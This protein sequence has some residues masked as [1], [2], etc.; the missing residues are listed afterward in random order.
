MCP[1]PASMSARKQRIAQHFAHATSYEQHAHIQQHVCQRL[2][3]QIQSRTPARLLE[4]GAGSGQLTRLLAAHLT[5]TAWHINE[6][7]DASRPSLQAL[8]P[9]AVLHIGDA[10][11]IDLGTAYD[12]IISANAI[13]WFDQ[14][15][16]FV[17]QSA[18]RLNIGGQLLFSTFT[19]NNFMQ[20]KTLLNQGLHYPSLLEWESVLRSAGLTDIKIQ[21]ERFEVPFASPYAVLKH[22]KLTGVSTNTLDTPFVWNKARLATFTQDYWATFGQVGADNAPYVPLTYEILT[23]SANKA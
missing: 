20:I 5:A 16:S 12:L 3:A 17:T 9:H 22:M 2:L 15:L 13:Q 1:A 18:A 8:L 19:P 6:L 11:T 23:V 14:P 7:N 21:T 4:V 10:E